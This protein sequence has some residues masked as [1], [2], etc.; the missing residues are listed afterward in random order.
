MPVNITRG[1]LIAGMVWFGF[2]NQSNICDLYEVPR[3]V[4]QIHSN[5]FNACLKYKLASLEDFA[6]FTKHSMVFS[7]NIGYM[8][9]LDE[10]GLKDLHVDKWLCDVV[11]PKTLKGTTEGDPKRFIA[12]RILDVLE[13]M[14]RK[15]DI[16][17][18][19]THSRI[20]ELFSIGM[21]VTSHDRT[22]WYRTLDK[23]DYTARYYMATY[24]LHV[25][26]PFP[27]TKNILVD[28]IGNDWGG[29]FDNDDI[30]NYKKLVI[31]MLNEGIVPGLHYNYTHRFVNGTI[32]DLCNS[33][34]ESFNNLKGLA[35]VSALKGR[36]DL[37]VFPPD[38][39][40]E[41]GEWL[42]YYRDA[43]R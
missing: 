5:I 20:S 6:P 8:S 40:I 24:M 35:L 16:A 21:G 18:P 19:L 28:L 9:M 3:N 32:R 42:Y 1:E 13:F 43:K 38:F 27:D 7:D 36:Q 4:P 15:R 29:I 26:I 34:H 37:S 31:H 12:Y 41:F 23:M 17:F 2:I 11:L 14:T 22:F 10:P 30:C 33:I 25:G 39:F